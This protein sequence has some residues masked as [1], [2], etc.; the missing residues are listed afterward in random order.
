MKKTHIIISILLLFL[1]LISCTG[2]FGYATR[3]PNDTYDKVSK[4]SFG[5]DGDEYVLE[6]KYSDMDEFVSTIKST[7]KSGKVDIA[8]A[9]GQVKMPCDDSTV[10]D[11]KEAC[12]IWF[13]LSI[14]NG[15]Y[16]KLFF[17]MNKNDTQTIWIYATATD[18]YNDGSFL[19]Y[20]SCDCKELVE[21]ATQYAE[22]IKGID[23]ATKIEIVKYDIGEKV[24][25]VTV[26]DETSVKHIVDNLNSL[27]LKE[28]EYNEPIAIEYELVFY[29]TDG[30]IMKTISITLDGW[31]DY[32]GFLH[33]VI[34]GELDIAYIEGLFE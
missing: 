5:V 25:T 12:E 16:K 10:E 1:V 33:S 17:T 8:N 11:N 22:S 21:L 14:E 20:Y 18:S 15:K 29:D 9:F 31:V 4:V 26:T 34:N 13:E 6:Y 24:G 32:H 23:G 2:C 27:K 19:E 28:L 7:L 30:E 3:L